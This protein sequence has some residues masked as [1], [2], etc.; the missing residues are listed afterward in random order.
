MIRLPTFAK[1]KVESLSAEWETLRVIEHEVGSIADWDE[2][3]LLKLISD[4]N[5]YAVTTADRGSW[6]FR[7]TAEELA[8]IRQ[9]L[10]RIMVKKELN[11]E[12]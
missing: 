4:Y 12:S 7:W 11:H 2:A 8:E 1:S 9:Q 6:R 10:A 3:R 5:H